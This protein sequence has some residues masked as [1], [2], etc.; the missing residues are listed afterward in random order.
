MCGQNVELLHIIL[1][2]H[3]VTTRLTNHWRSSSKMHASVCSV[4]H[5]HDTRYRW[6]VIYCRYQL[7]LYSGLAGFIVGLVANIRGGHQTRDLSCRSHQFATGRAD[8]CWWLLCALKRSSLVLA[9]KERLCRRLW[10]KSWI[11]KLVRKIL[12]VYVLGY[13]LP[14]CSCVVIERLGSH[15]T[16]ISESLFEI[17]FLGDES[18]LC[19]KYI[20]AVY[21]LTVWHNLRLKRI[22]LYSA[23]GNSLCI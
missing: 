18:L 6:A 1:A 7:P 5:N 3:I 13:L 17:F 8:D 23:F 22:I 20:E 15:W 14:D 11:F 9:Q 21:N 16:D 2:V 12:I 10:L 4:V 19:S